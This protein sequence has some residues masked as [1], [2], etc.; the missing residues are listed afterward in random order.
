MLN[1]SVKQ[2]RAQLAKM[3]L[4]AEPGNTGRPLTN[5]PAVHVRL[6]KPGYRPGD[7]IIG[8]IEIENV[9]QAGAAVPPNS[10]GRTS[11]FLAL[12]DPGHKAAAPF[13]ELSRLRSSASADD[14][15]GVRQRA[16]PAGTIFLEDVVVEV[17]GVERLDPTWIAVPKPLPGSAHPRGE[18]SILESRPTVI[19]SGVHIEAGG[20]RTYSIRTTLPKVLP[21]TYRGTAV[22]YHYYLS[23]M[24]KRRP[25]AVPA[26]GNGAAA[27]VPPAPPPVVEARVPIRVWVL[28]NKSGLT[29]EELGAEDHYGTGGIVPVTPVE[30]EIRWREKITRSSWVAAAEPSGGGDDDE[31][32]YP[33][34]EEGGPSSEGLA[35]SR[36]R[37]AGGRAHLMERIASSSSAAPPASVAATATVTE[38]DDG[39]AAV[40]PDP[41]P[42]AFLSGDGA[43]GLADSFATPPRAP[44]G[45]LEN[46]EGSMPRSRG[47]FIE[48]PRGG[49]RGV[50]GLR[51]PS[52]NGGDPGSPSWFGSPM[53]LF[54][55]FGNGRAI[56]LSKLSKRAEEDEQLLA[57]PMS[58][59]V[60]YL[61][62]RTYNIRIDDQI[63]VKFTPRSPQS[64]YYLGDVVSGTLTFPQEST[65]RC[66]EVSVLLETHEVV[67]P[68]VLHASRRAGRP[69]SVAKGPLH[70][71]Q[72][73]TEFHEVTAHLL[74]T[75]FLF[76]IPMDAPAAFATPLVSIQWVLRFEFVALRHRSGDRSRD[77]LGLPLSADESERGEWSMPIVVHAPLPRTHPPGTSGL[78]AG[79]RT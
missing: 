3:S 13:G 51:G 52:L 11:S 16:W 60:S 14:L 32:D 28:P 6:A 37:A 45:A 5:S 39:G 4:P 1:G 42:G 27:E 24:V 8:S 30:V 61:R 76:T 44:P 18:R 7:T 46:G 69:A 79:V 2:E 62:G 31:S 26:A 59:K 56:G 55:G 68:M 12:G 73:Q 22:R 34:E 49:E 75:H 67:N 25:D 58:P 21:P 15:A 57:S 23:V 65:R 64:T 77:R 78:P 74:T 43:G 9:L 33:R 36:S 48:I 50:D 63:L 66:L 10:S 70:L 19:V 41:P 17:K 35:A 29:T 47:P 53:G 40:G 71:P 38:V 72:V 20:T 54:D